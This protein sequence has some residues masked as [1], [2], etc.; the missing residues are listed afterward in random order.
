MLAS[1][2]KAINPEQTHICGKTTPP[3]VLSVAGLLMEN[4]SCSP[5]FC[6]NTTADLSEKWCVTRP[7]APSQMETPVT[8]GRVVSSD[9]PQAGSHGDRPDS[10]R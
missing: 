5:G 4:Q 1:E 9:G 2:E 10:H 7:E 6:M 8:S 3:R